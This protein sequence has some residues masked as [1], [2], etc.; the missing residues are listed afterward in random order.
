M[1]II[2][3]FTEDELTEDRI[4]HIKCLHIIVECKGMIV[5]RVLVDNNSLNVCPLITIDQLGVDRSFL[6]EKRMIVRAFNGFKSVATGEVDLVL[7]TGPCQFEVPYIAVDIPVTF[8]MLLGCPW[9][10]TSRAVL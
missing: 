4:S 7:E 9:I 1:T 8:N 10:H 2:I 6:R 5:P 3:T